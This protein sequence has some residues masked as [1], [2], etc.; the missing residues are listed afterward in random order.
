MIV[1]IFC[2][3]IILFEIMGVKDMFQGFDADDNKINDFHQ[4]VA[5]KNIQ[6][7]D[8]RSD[9]IMS[10]KNG[11]IGML[12]GILVGGV[13]G[14]LFLSPADQGNKEQ[15]IPVIRRPVVPFKIQP[16]D[17]GGMNIDNQD[18]EIYHIVDNTSKVVEEVKVVPVPETPKL[19]VEN[20]IS[21]SVDMDNLVES[22]SSQEDISIDENSEN[23]K[24]ANVQLETIPT[25]SSQKI[26][27]P[28]KIEDIKVNIQES[29][30]KAET[31]V[32]AKETKEVVKAPEK[33]SKQVAEKTTIKGTWYT[34][35][36]ASSSRQSVESLWKRLSTKHTFLKSYPHTVEE[37]T[38]AT[39][40]KLY[41]LKVGSFKTRKEAE[42][43]SIKLKQQKI[44]SIIKQN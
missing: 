9:D 43:L 4:R 44:S 22:I 36:I 28:E 15:T 32:E 41:R 20:N 31:K 14:W 2:F 24:V 5:D 25:N 10:A 42:Q 37:I 35:L 8:A 12:A 26:S 27:I 16:N 6:S 17:P 40:S 34:Q 29:I 3:I 1:N 19:V 33:A 11:F 39:G 13:V 21:N 30:N 7:F 23:I 18:R 38:S